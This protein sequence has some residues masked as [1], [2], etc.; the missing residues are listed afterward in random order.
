[1]L[2]H[3]SYLL[4]FTV[5]LDKE[6]GGPMEMK[7]EEAKAGGFLSPQGNGGYYRFA[8]PCTFYGSPLPSEAEGEVPIHRPYVLSPIPLLR[9]KVNSHQF[10]RNLT[11]RPCSISSNLRGIEVV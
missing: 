3:F 1:V 7:I 2:I 4:L 6:G 5:E 11:L 8:A 10:I 9:M